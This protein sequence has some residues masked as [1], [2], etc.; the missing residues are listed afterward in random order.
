MNKLTA[1]NTNTAPDTD[2]AS[3]INILSYEIAIQGLRVHGSTPWLGADA[4][5]AAAETIQLI[6]AQLTVLPNGK[7]TFT[8]ICGGDSRNVM[9]ENCRFTVTLSDS[10]VPAD[11]AKELL[12]Q[13]LSAG[14]A[15]APGTTGTIKQIGTLKKSSPEK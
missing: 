13:A 8:T 7:P 3:D 11:D 2:T 6:N 4:I 15:E 12:Q 10:F 1:L 5:I 9:A 14:L